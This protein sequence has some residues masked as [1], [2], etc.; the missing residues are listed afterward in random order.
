[1]FSLHSKQ[2]FNI[3]QLV[4]RVLIE[5]VHNF[6][7]ILCEFVIN[8]LNSFLCIKLNHRM[9]FVLDFILEFLVEV[10]VLGRLS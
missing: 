9:N 3:H 2:S 5:C 10:L 6:L 8:Q 7:M 1:M 4:I